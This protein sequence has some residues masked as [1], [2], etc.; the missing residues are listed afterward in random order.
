MTFDLPVAE[1]KS[2]CLLFLIDAGLMITIYR[3]RAESRAT[4][5]PKQN[6]ERCQDLSGKSKGASGPAAGAGKSR[7]PSGQP[8]GRCAFG[9]GRLRRLERPRGLLHA[10]RLS[11]GLRCDSIAR[12]RSRTDGLLCRAAAGKD[13]LLESA[14]PP[15]AAGFVPVFFTGLAVF[16]AALRTWVSITGSAGL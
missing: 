16:L 8:R 5:H 9:M 1:T 7:E 10:S 6:R 2:M 11:G 14:E 12:V 15:Q 13:Q 3:N 4:E